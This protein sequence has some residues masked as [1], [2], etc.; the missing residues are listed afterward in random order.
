M[1]SPLGLHLVVVVGISIEGHIQEVQEVD[2]NGLL[3][4]TFS[5]EFHQDARHVK[6]TFHNRL[7]PAEYSIVGNELGE[8]GREGRERGCD[9][10]ETEC[11]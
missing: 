1:V 6:D 7:I 10:L 9:V 5:N 8:G 2:G 3:F 11:W 4:Q